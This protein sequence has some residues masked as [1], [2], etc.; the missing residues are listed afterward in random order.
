L[1]LR[2]PAPIWSPIRR[3]DGQQKGDDAPHCLLFPK[4]FTKISKKIT[5]FMQR[6]VDYCS[7]WWYHV[8]QDNKKQVGGI[9]EWKKKL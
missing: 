9:G 1:P 2:F 8:C 7:F 3:P 4:I 5:I 6:N